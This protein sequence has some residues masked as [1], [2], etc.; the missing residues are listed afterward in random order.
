MKEVKISMFR[1][2]V[3]EM[4]ESK[5]NERECW[6]IFDTRDMCNHYVHVSFHKETEAKMI[7]EGAANGLITSEYPVWV[8]KSIYLLWYGERISEDELYRRRM[9]LKNENLTLEDLRI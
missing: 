7:L 6:I 4:R 8:Q 1:Q 2:G 9:E 3:Y 5:I